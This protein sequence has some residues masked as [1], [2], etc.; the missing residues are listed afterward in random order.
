M[1]PTDADVC[2]AAA[3]VED[4]TLRRGLGELGMVRSVQSGRRQ[5][6]VVV[7]LPVEGWPATDE[8]VGLVLRAVGA[9]PGVGEVKVELATM[10]A[11]ER[12]RAPPPSGDRRWWR[13][14]AAD[15]RR[16]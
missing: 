12:E 10:T 15:D 16:G 2:A 6:S 9:V 3:A 5:S 14:R 4:P 8:L 7:A 1:V 13:A 11:N